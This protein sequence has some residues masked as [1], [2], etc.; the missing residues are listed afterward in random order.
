M[1][2]KDTVDFSEIDFQNGEVI[3]IDKALNKSSFNVV[4]KIRK[5]VHVQKVG[6]AGTLDPLAT[7]MLIICTGKKTKTIEQ[8][9]EL[10]KT[11]TGIITLGKTT[12][13]MDRE[14]EIIE[15]KPLTG[16]S[17]EL[18]EKTRLQFIGTINQIPPM[19]SAVKFKGK[20]LYKY[21][22][23]GIEIERKPREIK[24]H[25]FK[26]LKSDLPDLHFEITCSKGTYIRVI[27]H[28]FG[29]QLSCGGFLSSLRRTRIG[30][31]KVENALKIEEF[32]Q[33]AALL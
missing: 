19:Y 15:E 31:F 10:E 16:V 7:G 17:D 11:Y 9:Q 6:H 22:R 29:Q 24:I 13:S 8:F 4:Y 30:Q 21:A 14:S 28:D 25:E 3:L 26:I 32:E 1:I 23:K 27:A 20:S 18:I 12:L 5:A 33:R 2:T